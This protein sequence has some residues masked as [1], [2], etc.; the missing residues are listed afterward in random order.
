M[1]PNSTQ[2]TSGWVTTATGRLCST[3]SSRCLRRTVA[4]LEREGHRRAEHQEERR[5]HPEQQVL[6]DVEAEQH[7]VVL[8]EP[9]LGGERDARA[10]GR[11]R[12]P[13]TAPAATAGPARRAAA[14]PSSRAPPAS[15]VSTKSGSSDQ[16]PKQRPTTSASPGARE[17]RAARQRSPRPRV[18]VCHHRRVTDGV[19]TEAPTRA[20]F[21]ARR[22]HRGL[23]RVGADV[24]RRALR[25]VL[26]PAVATRRSGRRAARAPRAARRDARNAR[27]DRLERHDPPR[28]RVAREHGDRVRDAAV[29]DHHVRARRGLPR[30]PDPRVLRA[31]LLGRRRA[32]SAR[33][34]T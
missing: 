27:A 21:A 4:R 28:R 24:L 30:Q 2:T 13:P 32:R 9:G 15:T 26:H 31:R 5:D 7:P 34:T 1:P 6:D 33:C 11:R 29:A 25:R 22:G 16:S 3:R 10:A 18:A 19:A 8:R 12:T 23:A 20:A 14:R 17:S